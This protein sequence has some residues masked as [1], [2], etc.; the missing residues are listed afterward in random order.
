MC[1]EVALTARN[2]LGMLLFRMLEQ[3][4]EGSRD[5]FTPVTLIGFVV[6]VWCVVRLV[7][8][9]LKQG[10]RRE[11]LGTFVTL[12]GIQ[13]VDSLLVGF[14]DHLRLGDVIAEVAI[15]CDSLMDL[16]IMLANGRSRHPLSFANG[17]RVGE[18]TG[19]L[20]GDLVIVQLDS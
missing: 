17:A 7:Q 14:N 2:V 13:L 6:P 3:F 19:V 11:C 10:G 15:V 1:Q 12:E 4:L 9:L 8:M 18:G 5:Q 20:H 16:S